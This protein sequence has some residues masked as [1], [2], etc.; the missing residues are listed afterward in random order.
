MMKKH[1]MFRITLIAFLLI[2]SSAISAQDMDAG[3]SLGVYIETYPQIPVI[4]VPWLFTLLVDH[5]V[6]DEV[7]VIAPSFAPQLSMDRLIKS[8]RMTASRLQTAVQ[9][10]FILNTPG[11]YILGSFTVIT[12]YGITE[13][14]PYILEIPGPV[15]EQRTVSPQ[16][17][18]EGAPAQMAAG[19]R[20]V[21]ALRVTDWNSGRLPQEF[22]MPEVP[23]GAILEALPLAV[24]ERSRGIVIKLGLIPLADFS[25]PSRILRYENLV[26]E[27]PALYI[28]VT[29]AASRVIERETSGQNTAYIVPDSEKISDNTHAPFP[30]FDLASPDNLFFR[31]IILDRVWYAQ[32]ESIY[33]TVRDLWDSGF[34][35]QALAELRQ[36]EREHPAGALLQPI[37]REA[38]EN[39]L[40]F[41]T[42]NESRWQRRLL[43]G[44]S[45]LLFFLVIIV[46]FVCFAFI[47]KSFQKRAVLYPLLCAVVFAILGFAYIYIFLDSRSVFSGN[48]SRFG[49]TNE[50]PVRRTADFE[51]EELFSFREGQPVVIM[52]NSGTW[53]FVRANDK[54]GISGWIPS[55]KVIFY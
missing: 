27:I 54:T 3:E 34:Y 39:L 48:E 16:I 35:V 9:Y 4:G 23:R 41:N 18:W 52:L 22:F 19:E 13:T 33:N 20:A 42:E 30:D 10:R 46:P 44:F 32:C 2:F 26:F 12:P 49:V 1:I 5:G 6:P 17:V 37:R 7:T 47:R 51:G 40:F 24:E 36:N 21:L 31:K 53:V 8:P 11:R 29:S 45:F 38:E 43:L 15:T 14:E 50:T 28:R 55:E 25:L